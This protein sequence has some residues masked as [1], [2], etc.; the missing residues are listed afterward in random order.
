MKR[1]II[2]INLVLFVSLI[3]PAQGKGEENAA[4][5]IGSNAK[6]IWEKNLEEPSYT[7]LLS[8]GDKI[9]AVTK[10]GTVNCFDTQGKL[11]WWE[12]IKR[13]I[14]SRPI[15]YEGNLIIAATNGD[16]ISLDD[17]AGNIQ[18]SIGLDESLTS[19]L[20]SITLDNQ[21]QSTTAAIVGT[22]KGSIYC[23][24]VSTFE[25]IWE[26]HSAAGAII[27]KP[28]WVMN[29]I[30]YT[31]EDGYLYCIDSRS[32]M[33]IWK[34]SPPKGK[35]ITFENSAPVSDGRSVFISLPD[36]SVYSIDLMLGKTNWKNSYTNCYSSTGILINK[37]L[38]FIKSQKDDI[39]S[40]N[41]RTGKIE[42]RYDAGF[43]QDTT[44]TEFL[45]TGDNILFGTE[46]GK[47][48]AIEKGIRVTPLLSLGNTAI[49][50]IISLGND[51]YAASNGS[52]EM[53]IF[54][55][56]F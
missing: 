50:N 53:V 25:M 46:S 35:G 40:L 26:N 54:S 52:G 27:S 20:I 37:E 41:A 4:Q 39:Y 21:G 12:N 33:L 19:H 56:N 24:D 51:K 9:F 15:D 23:Y 16:L 42:R 6:I 32:G 2:L 30:I 10:K 29:K 45:F 11:I 3:C 7:S 44:A 5:V 43:G 55:V 36:K 22:A 49:Y 34:W 18:Q 14:A 1:R 13:E 8:A 38:L 31:S 47:I 28:I 48:Y 17:T